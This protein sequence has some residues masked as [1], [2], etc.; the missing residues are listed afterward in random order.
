VSQDTHPEAETQLKIWL[1]RGY[2][3]RGGTKLDEERC[4]LVRALTQ[5]RRHS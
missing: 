2:T 1:Y 4:V 3:L 5:G